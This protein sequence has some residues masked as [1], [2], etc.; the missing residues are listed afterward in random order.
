M[1]RSWTFACSILHVFTLCTRNDIPV[2]GG[3]E[4]KGEG[5]VAVHG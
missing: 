5:R 3:H 4:S 1:P 2:R